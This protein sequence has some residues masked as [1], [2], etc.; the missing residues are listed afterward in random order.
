MF[1]MCGFRSFIIE[2]WTALDLVNALYEKPGEENV[3]KIIACKLLEQMF[4]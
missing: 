4:L 3:A 2:C 1:Y